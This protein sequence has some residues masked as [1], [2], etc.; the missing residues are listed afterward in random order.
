MNNEKTFDELLEELELGVRQSPK[1]FLQSRIKADNMKYM[2]RFIQDNTPKLLKDG[3]YSIGTIVHWIIH[4]LTEFPKCKICGKPFADKNVSALGDYPTYCSSACQHKDPDCIEKIIDT[5]QSNFGSREAQEELRI[6]REQT[7]KERYGDKHYNNRE[8]MKKTCMEKYGV[9]SVGASKEIQEK[10]R[11]TCIERYGVSNMFESDIFK[12]K[13]KNTKLQKYGD[14]CFNNREQAKETMTEKYDGGTTMQSVELRRKAEQTSLE[15]YGVRHYANPEK[16]KATSMK[17]YGK[18]HHMKTEESKTIFRN[19]QDARLKKSYIT[20]KKNGT[21]K[22]SIAEDVVYGKLLT[23]FPKVLRQYNCA[24]Y[25][26]AVDFYI[27][28]CD[29][30][31]EFNGCWTHGGH[32]YDDTSEKDHDLLLEWM[33]KSNE[34]PFYRNAIETWTVRDVRKR[35]TAKQNNLNYIELWNMDDVEAFVTKRQNSRMEEAK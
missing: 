20:K 31:I 22:K 30:F 34:H 27:P 6:R 23:V 7:L 9:E 1:G 8:Q 26:F 25:P 17:R 18:T 21:F 24:R 14:A 2:R 10:I 11:R 4:G 13:S 19:N 32:P 15:R 16:S 12:E 28:A 5:Y 3:N 35:E 33:G 29:L